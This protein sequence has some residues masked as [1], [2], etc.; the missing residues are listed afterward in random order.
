MAYRIIC[1]FDRKRRKGGYLC[2]TDPYQDLVAWLVLMKQPIVQ[3]HCNQYLI[4][5]QEVS[6]QPVECRMLI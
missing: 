4:R 2:T 1:P 6:H 3:E 5:A